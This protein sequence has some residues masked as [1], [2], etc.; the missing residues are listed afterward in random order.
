MLKE[1]KGIKFFPHKWD[2]SQG[3][4]YGHIS[5]HVPYDTFEEGENNGYCATNFQDRSGKYQ[6]VEAC[7]SQ[8]CGHAA[9]GWGSATLKDALENAARDCC[10]NL[11]RKKQEDIVVTVENEKE[12]WKSVQKFTIPSSNKSAVIAYLLKALQTKDNREC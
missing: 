1:I 7:N 9:K 10:M 5:F 4:E 3:G 11:T 6:L 12:P 2:F 8:E